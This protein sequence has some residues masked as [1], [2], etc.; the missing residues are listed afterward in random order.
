D[1][2]FTEGKHALKFGFNFLH[3]YSDYTTSGSR[4]LFTF[5]GSQLGDNL[6]AST[7]TPKFGGLAGLIDLLAGLPTP[8]NTSISRVL[9]DRSKTELC[10]APG[11]RVGSASCADSWSSDS[12]AGRVRDLL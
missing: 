3:N 2:N 6:L 11:T 9:S 8:G 5:D 10:A 12:G 4:G 7:S 1:L